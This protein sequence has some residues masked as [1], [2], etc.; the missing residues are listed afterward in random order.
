M[1]IRR[2]IVARNVPRAAFFAACTMAVAHYAQ[3][4]ACHPDMGH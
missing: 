2:K 3:P 4:R 1:K